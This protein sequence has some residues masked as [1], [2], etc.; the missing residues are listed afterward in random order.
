MGRPARRIATSDD[1]DDAFV[2][3]SGAA[4]K[5]LEPRRRP[6]P[7]PTV[8]VDATSQRH[9]KESA[10]AAASDAGASPKALEPRR[11]PLPCPTVTVDA[12]SQSPGKE[13][14]LAVVSDAGAASE[15]LEPRRRPLP[16]P[17][18]TVDA[19][20]QR[21]GQESALAAASDGVSFF[22]TGGAGTGKSYV[23]RQIIERLCPR[24]DVTSGVF[25][26]GSTGAA[27]SALEGTTLHSFCG[28]G[29]GAGTVDSLIAMVQSNRA[30][31]KRWRECQVLIVDEV[32]ML[33]G[34]FFDRIEAV[35][36]AVRNSTLP[37][38]GIQLILC[39]DFFQLPPV[40]ADEPDS[41]VVY[42]FE[43]RCWPVVV[44]RSVILQQV[45][46]QSDASFVRLLDELRRGSLS[47]FSLALLSRMAVEPSDSARARQP[48]VPPATR[49]CPLNAKCDHHNMAMLRSLP[50]H[51]R[52]YRSRDEG[53]SPELLGACA[54]ATSI[55]LRVGALVVLIKNVDQLKGLTNGTRAVVVGWGSHPR[56]AH[57]GVDVSE[58]PLDGPPV[59][60]EWVARGAPQRRRLYPEIQVVKTGLRHLLLPERFVVRGGADVVAS[61][62]QLPIKLGWGLSV[63]RAQGMTLD[64]LEVDLAGSFAPG[65]VRASGAPRVRLGAPLDHPPTWHLACRRLSVWC[66]W[67]RCFPI[68][69]PPH[70][71]AQPTGVRGAESCDK[72]A[73][74]A[75][76]LVRPSR[77]QGRPQGGGLLPRHRRSLASSRWC[78][79]SSWHHPTPRPAGR[80]HGRKSQRRRRATERRDQ[81]SPCVCLCV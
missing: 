18:V 4:P 66:L 17:T 39:G 69:V 59:P 12:T 60:A 10:L 62:C 19:I 74:H 36:R 20:S 11:R 53:P 48:D 75:H 76:P 33:D 24:P 51:D 57:V 43:A 52:V 49:L 5:A 65:M 28:V 64:C 2:G 77:D 37:F 3:V 67:R 78:W 21:H 68:D 32:S 35:A 7:C 44:T 26:T 38:G 61:R 27:A 40:G 70:P 54:A 58:S 63:H 41:G 56:P 50:G 73:H 34:V 8:T 45:F 14:A 23:L 16:C 15:A 79:P 71:L 46:R 81:I 31:K 22:L 29:Q 13:S 9:G 47:S 6:L 30:A 25:V 55:A 80:T 1:E 72:S 42:L